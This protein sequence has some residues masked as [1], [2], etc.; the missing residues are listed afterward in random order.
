[1]L[2][3]TKKSYMY[4]RKGKIY[5]TILKIYMTILRIYIE[6]FYDKTITISPKEQLVC[7]P[8][9]LPLNT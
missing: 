6:L 1:M 9:Y 8:N 3:H 7:I 4:V 2:H 5:M